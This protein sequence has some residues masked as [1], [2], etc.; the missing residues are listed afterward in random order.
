[1]MVVNPTSITRFCADDLWRSN[2]LFE[3]LVQHNHA[4]HWRYRLAT[5]V[6]RCCRDGRGEYGATGMLRSR[7]TPIVT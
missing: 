2:R 4:A 6:S 3:H 7:H 5:G 1:M